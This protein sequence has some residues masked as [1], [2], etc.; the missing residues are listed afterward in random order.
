MAEQGHTTKLQNWLDRLRNGDR[1]ALD[2]LIEHACERLRL[3]ARKMLKG[4]R[5]GRWSE[6]ADVLQHA[7][8]RLHRT[9][10]SK[11][12]A[13]VREFYA[14]ATRAIR[15]ELIDLARHY[16]GAEGR[17][18]HHQSDDGRLAAGKPAL[19]P[20]SLEAWAKFHEAVESLPEQ[21]REVVNLLWYEELGQAEAADVLGISLATLK[22]RWQAARITL[23]EK[24]DPMDFA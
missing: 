22:R 19:E 3:V 15:C 10:A 20:T 12:P 14:W 11:Q 21:E 5:V 1:E 24:L 4:D 2:G 9:L 17:G 16:Y 13:N 6:T 8:L 18:Q 23:R 7:M